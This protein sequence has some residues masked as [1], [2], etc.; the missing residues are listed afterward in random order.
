MSALMTPERPHQTETTEAERMT[1]PQAL[2]RT[3][4]G[5]LVVAAVSMPTGCKDSKATAPAP[6]PPVKVTAV[7]QQDVPIYREWVGSTVG[8]VSAQIRARVTGYLVSQNYQEGR[9]V[10]TGDLMFQIDPRPYQ[11]SL[12]QA[13]GKLAQTESQKAQA[14]SQVTQTESQVE[15]AKAGVAQAEGDLARAVATQKKT[16]L[17]VERYTP[18]AS[19]GSVSQQEL[20]N[21]TQNNLANLAS[22]DAS[23]AN[24][25][26]A[27]ANVLSAQAAVEKAKADVSAAQANIIQAKAGLDEAQLN[28]GWTKVLSPISGIAGIKKVDIGDLVTTT[29]VLTTVA[30][31]DPIYVQFSLAEQEY[32]RWRAGHPQ[33]RTTQLP[34]FGLILSDGSTYPYQG[35]ADILG[36]EVDTTT[37]TIPVRV[38]FPNPGNL[39]RPGQFGKVR[40]AIDVVHGALLVPQ[41]A[42]QDLQGLYQVG[43]V[44]ADDAVTVQNVQVGD[45]FGTFWVITKGLKPG[46]RVIVEGLEK[47]R[48]GEKVT[49]TVVQAEAPSAGKPAAPSGS[50][51]A[52]PASS[53]TK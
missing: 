16:Q 18:L 19:R 15:Q 3:L 6:R 32:L 9:V 28:I 20:D 39:L 51:G 52:P 17:E 24:V 25:E 48:A 31:I 34:G 50:P 35:A 44:G 11:N 45:R 22:V 43:I 12:D 13:K 5:L 27:K 30:Q 36:L 47:V 21:A 1:F 38:A 42:V 33:P 53:A 14:Q 4:G 23:K 40:F 41:R 7:I 49:P 10:K 26:K 2:A 29:T 46:E 37:G 8:Y